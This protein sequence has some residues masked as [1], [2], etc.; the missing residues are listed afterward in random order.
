MPGNHEGGLITARKI[1]ERDPDHYHRIGAIG[2]QI[3]RGGGFAMMSHEQV[4]AAGRKGG[5]KSRR[6]RPQ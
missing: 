1:K 6:N 3:S 4:V 2:G 5:T